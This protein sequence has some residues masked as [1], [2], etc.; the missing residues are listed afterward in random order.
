METAENIV[1]KMKQLEKII[2]GNILY[3]NMNKI[4]TK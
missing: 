3:I 1:V 2:H 4:V